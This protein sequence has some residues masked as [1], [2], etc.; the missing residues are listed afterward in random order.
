MTFPNT[1]ARH[2]TAP[3]PSQ[4]ELGWRRG[5]TRCQTRILNFKPTLSLSLSLRLRLD[6]RSP[7]P[8]HSLNGNQPK[9]KWRRSESE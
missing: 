4:E 7:T 1:S 8:A 5:R 3:N 2:S 6:S 9:Q